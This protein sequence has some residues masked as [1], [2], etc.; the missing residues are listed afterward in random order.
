MFYCL[1]GDAF[2]LGIRTCIL[3]SQYV[4]T[5]LVVIITSD[6]SR[7]GL[8]APMS[9][10]AILQVADALLRLPLRHLLPIVEPLKGGRCGRL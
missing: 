10:C 2:A 6:V 5:T 8:F 3:R 7:E 9:L 1:E 4:L